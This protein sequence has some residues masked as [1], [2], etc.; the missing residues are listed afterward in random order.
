MKKMTSKEI[1]DQI[2]AYK[3]K[4]GN[5]EGKVQVLS[6][7]LEQFKTEYD[8][9][10]QTC[11]NNYGCKPKDLKNLIT[12]KQSELESKLQELQD[13]VVELEGE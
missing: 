11:K 13:K 10:V 6:T 8:D 2:E 12:N 5:A 3:K 4:K 9:L 1:L 7:Q